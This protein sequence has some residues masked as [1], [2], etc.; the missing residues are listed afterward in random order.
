MPNDEVVAA[1]TIPV[2][3]ATTIGTG[4][5]AVEYTDAVSLTVLD[6]DKMTLS[7][8]ATRWT[9]WMLPG[10]SCDGDVRCC[11]FCSGTCGY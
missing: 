2:N 7:L 9:K 11:P 4:D 5:D 3:A 8:S 1:T 6:D 10:R